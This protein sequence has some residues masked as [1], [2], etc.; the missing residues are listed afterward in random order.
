MV[1][2]VGLGLVIAFY[3]IIAGVGLWAAW[4]TRNKVQDGDVKMVGNRDISM[5]VGIFTMTATW[6]G[7]G[8]INGTAEEVYVSGLLWVQSPIGYSLSMILGGMFYAV[9]MRN[10]KYTTMIDPIQEVFG[11]VAGAIL[12]LPAVMGEL[13]WSASILA[14]LGT[15]LAVII[16]LPDVPTIIVSA[17]IAIGY[18]LFGGLYAVAYTD[19]VQLSLIIVGLF[20]A[21]PFIVTN[22]HIPDGGIIGNFTDSTPPWVGSIEKDSALIW[23]DN[24]L[25]LIMGGIPWQVYFQRVL[26]AN[27]ARSA[28]ILSYAAPIGCIALALPPIFIGAAGSLVVWEDIPDFAFD[29]VNPSS[30]LP[31]CLK[32]LCPP[33]VGYI[34]LAAVAAAVMS[35]ADSS[36]L[37]AASLLTVNTIRKLLDHRKIKLTDTQDTWVLR[38]SIILLGAIAVTM[39]CTFTSIYGLWFFSGD[40]VYSLLFPPLTAS[41]YSPNIVNDVGALTMFVTGLTVRLLSGE[42]VLSIPPVI[43]WPGFDEEKGQLFPFKTVIMLINACTLYIVSIAANYYRHGTATRPWKNI[44]NDDGERID[45]EVAVVEEE[46]DVGEEASAL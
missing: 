7:G 20:L 34:G 40:I 2:Y 18:T 5:V 1:D 32:Y 35:S 23:T 31:L 36:L 16:E 46:K 17:A 21:L 3:V 22:E 6:V 29:E 44:Y 15:T 39:A 4:H 11:S 9:K 37:S 45:K 30:I 13:F 14:A 24:M 10:R 27:S 41:L 12:S 19:V 28:Q 26:S 43:K 33:A 8:Y 38:G 25:M 42:D